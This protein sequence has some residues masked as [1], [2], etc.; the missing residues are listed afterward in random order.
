MEKYE[1][2]IPKYRKKTHKKST[3]KSNHKHDKIPCRV[4][5]NSMYGNKIMEYDLLGW[6]CSIC[7]KV[8]GEKIISQKDLD[9]Y[10]NLEVKEETN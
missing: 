6:Y 9:K 5:Y 8:C 1:N 3:K 7:G 10:S 2:D 4:H